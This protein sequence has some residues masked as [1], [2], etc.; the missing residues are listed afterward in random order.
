MGITSAPEVF[1]RKT[2]KILEGIDGV[3]ILLD[4]FLVFGRTKEEHDRRLAEVLERLQ[5]FGVTLNEEKCKFGIE[6]VTFLGHKVSERGISTDPKKVEAVLKLSPPKNV[7]EVRRFLGMVNHYVKFLPQLSDVTAPIRA[8]LRKDVVWVWDSVQEQSFKQ[9]KSLLC[10]APVLAYFDLNRSTRIAVDASQVGLGAVLEQ[11]QDKEEWKPVM[12]ASRSL[13]DTEQRYSNIERE[14]LG[15]LWG[16]EKFQEYLIG[17]QF[18]VLTDHKPLVTLLGKKPLMDLS[19]RLQRFRMRLARFDFKIEYTPGKTFFTPDTL[20]RDPL[21]IQAAE[22]V[23]SDQIE[24]YVGD[25]F[26]PKVKDVLLKRLLEEQKADPVMTDIKEQLSKVED[27]EWKEHLRPFRQFKEELWVKGDGLLMFKNRVVVPAK[28][29]K[30]ILVKLHE[31]HGGERKTLALARN[32]VWWPGI[33]HDVKNKIASCSSCVENRP[34]VQEP[35]IPTEI[36]KG[37]WQLLAAD[38]FK[39]GGS[40]YLVVADFYS[41]FVDIKKM[42][43]MTT[44]ATINFFKTLFSKFGIP[45]AV[46]CDNGSNLTSFEMKKFAQEMGF[47]ILTNSPYHAQGNGFAESMVKLSKR[48]LREGDVELGLLAYRSTPLDIGVSPAELLMGRRIRNRLPTVQEAYRPKWPILKEVQAKMERTQG[49]SKENFDRR[50][51]A[52]ELEELEEGEKVWMRDQREYG[53]VVRKTGIR[54]Y[55]VKL[56]ERGGTMQRNRGSLVRCGRGTKKGGCMV[57]SR[58]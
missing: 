14:G 35:L 54:R 12:F 7:S 2:N 25:V 31:G 53:M 23:C 39:V 36:P 40:W 56:M 19:P 10:S 28:F 11:K 9:V 32:S 58:V 42:K 3:I 8:L 46:R 41:K 20:S 4:D 16:C 33:S 15:V 48:L 37:P 27:T 52:R 21:V 22:G 38:Y 47:E 13:T 24:A 45:L 50:H 30:E 57:V 17:T 29:R 6:E 55:E 51:G 18:T 1:H 34:K 5:K 43:S 44:S 26:K 49:K